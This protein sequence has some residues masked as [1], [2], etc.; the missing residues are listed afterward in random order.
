MATT[1]RRFLILAS[2]CLACLCAG[3][4]V[5]AGIIQ[6]GSTYTVT[7]TNFVTNYSQN[8]T[9]DGATHSVDNGLLQL[10]LTTVPDGPN[11]EWDVFS[12]TTTG[13]GP[14]ASN[15]NAN[16]QLDLT[17]LTF[18]EPVFFTGFFAQWTVDGSAVSPISPF[19]GIDNINPNPTGIVPGPV[20]GGLF[21]SSL[22]STSFDLP[23][24]I[25]VNPYSFVSSG[26]INPDT[27]NGFQAGLHFT[28]E[29]PQPVVAVP[30]PSSIAVFGAVGL[31]LLCS[32]PRRRRVAH[33]GS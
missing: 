17:G 30:E 24:L 25:F 14:L 16:W 15:L 28:L 2:V 27:A 26:G 10:T 23:N 29:N 12:F 13:G 31:G 33:R 7:G 8:V 9:V 21:A 5:H 22:A 11:A 6:P 20:Y 32:S 3:Q 4:T 1:H 19:G 18:S